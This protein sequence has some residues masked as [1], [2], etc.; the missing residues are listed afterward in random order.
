MPMLQYHTPPSALYHSTM[1]AP[2][3]P[4]MLGLAPPL[5]LF[6]PCFVPSCWG[7]GRSPGGEVKGG[8]ARKSLIKLLP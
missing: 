6:H 3:R 8:R 2:R 7:M 5:G 1:L 4:S